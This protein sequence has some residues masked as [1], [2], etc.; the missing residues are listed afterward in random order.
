LIGT[1]RI[2]EVWENASGCTWRIDQLMKRNIWKLKFGEFFNFPSR[3]EIEIDL[4]F[5]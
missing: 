1:R 2:G 3:I 4:N 5:F